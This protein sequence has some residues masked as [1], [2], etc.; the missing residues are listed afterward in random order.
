MKS[1]V[2]VSGATGS[3]GG[4]VARLLMESG[5][6][7]RVLS[8]DRRRCGSLIDLGAEVA[9]SDLR[10]PKGLADAVEGIGTVFVIPPENDVRLAERLVDAAAASGV[11]RIVRLSALGADDRAVSETLRAHAAGEAHLSATGVASVNL[12]CNS[13]MQNLDWFGPQIARDNEL[14][15]YLPEASIAWVD[16]RDIGSVA[17]AVIRAP[18]LPDK[19]L[20]VTG[21]ET[22]TLFEIAEV[23]S[24]ELGRKI[25]IVDLQSEAFVAR[26]VELGWAESAACEWTDI[27]GEEYYR[28]GAAGHIAT[29]VQVYGGSPPRTIRQ[30]VRELASQ[31]TSQTNQP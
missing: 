5:I 26:A 23:M 25:Q 24:D 13:F 1:T 10:D 30:Y 31:M 6:A 2:L 3:I 14:M 18:S 19:P 17:A 28:D 9:V 16:A 12:R 29:T 15:A 27:Y 8:R 7:V 20:E 4:E 11:D 22:L 21:G